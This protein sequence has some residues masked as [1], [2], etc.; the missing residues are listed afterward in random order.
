[1]NK[2][3]SLINFIIL[4][5][6]VIVVAIPLFSS[7]LNIYNE[8]GIHFYA[9]NYALHN[10][11]GQ[12][13]TSNVINSFANGYGY[14]YG[15]FTGKII[16]IILYFMT[17]IVSWSF[18]FK[19]LEFIF[20]A[21]SALTMY[22]L[23]KH[24]A[25][26][27]NIGLLAAGMYILLPYH[28]TSMYVRFDLIEQA[29]FVL[30]PLAFLGANY[31]IHG[32]RKF[33]FYPFAITL[34]LILNFPIGFI[35]T[36]LTA[37]YLGI[38]ANKI[39]ENKYGYKLIVCFIFVVFI[40]AYR[41][42]AYLQVVL[43][44]EFKINNPSDSAID[45]FIKKAISFK[46]LFVTA[47]TESYM[48]EVGPILIGTFCLIPMTII[49][50]K[51]EFR[52]DYIFMAVASIIFL[53]LSTKIF[54]W[55]IFARLAYKLESPYKLLSIATFFLC[56]ICSINVGNVLRNLRLRYD[57]ILLSITIIYTVFLVSHIAFGNLPNLDMISIGTI[58]G[59]DEEISAGLG[60]EEYLPSKAYDNK[61][62][63][64]TRENK[65]YVLSG[66]AII[67]DEEKVNGRLTARIKTI[68]EDT[69]FELPYIYYP[70]YVIKCDGMKANSIESENGFLQ[71]AITANEQFTLD[72]QYKYTTE[73]M[74]ANVMS[75]VATLVFIGYC[76]YTLTYKS[77]EEIMVEIEKELDS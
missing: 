63:I 8:E 59:K 21:L 7:N 46:K 4:F 32:D 27:K 18:A 22:K 49:S 50:I 41:W 75:F 66:K 17:N 36:I 62:Y 60:K 26:N 56:I 48:F 64:A 34:L 51:K 74:W 23:V 11:E 65:I 13:I 1:M 28:L 76:L 6:I 54:P 71:I 29:S 38:N 19:F 37:I 35:I 43:S 55:K 15:L 24:L 31:L 25:D 73:I 44:A 12:S 16:Q 39:K 47:K 5:S 69:V 53:I 67:E 70:G 61:F 68:D 30:I 2:K 42:L 57:I 33:F 9:Y 58:S 77:K 20:L 10:S 14:S 45:S 72:V 52:K 3:S 40:T